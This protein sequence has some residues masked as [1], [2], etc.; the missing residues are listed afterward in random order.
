MKSFDNDL[1]KYAEKI[2][3]KMSERRELR[4]RILTYMEYHPL[5]KQPISSG[6]LAIPSEAFVM[7][8]LKALHI[9]IIA[10]A[11]VLLFV[12]IPLAAEKSKP[13]DALYFVK[14]E[15]TEPL[16][17]QFA[18]TPYEK[19]EF[20]TKLLNKRI[21]EA[22][23]LASEGKLTDE[24][25]EQI[26]ETV[27]EH[28][29]AVQTGLAELRTQ[30]ADGA[31]IAQISV[32]SSLEVQ[33]AVLGAENSVSNTSLIESILTVVNDA[34]EDVSEQAEGTQ[35]SYEGLMAQVERETTRAFELLETVKETATEEEIRDIERRLNDINRLTSESKEK[36]SEPSGAEN[37]ATTL[38]LLQKL[39][40]FMTDID[41]R[42]SVSLE[43][44]VPVVLST[45]ERI[46]IVRKKILSVNE[47][48]AR[49][50]ERLPDLETR[51]MEE[52]ISE[53][54]N[55]ANELVLK[56]TAALD[57]SDIGT[58]ETAAD[59]AYAIATDLDTLTERINREDRE[60]IRNDEADG[61]ETAT[62]TEEVSEDN[63]TSTA[64][65]PVEDLEERRDA[66]ERI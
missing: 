38:G 65:V 33:S 27:K 25:K 45:E 24:V 34:R 36:R 14:T 42:E 26:T 29:N 23:A 41:V 44:I 51:G 47:V 53:G 28:T 1:K 39:I 10:G 11:F 5:K 19:I 9:R 15:L 17:G 6:D 59:E 22:R 18:K 16:Q 7:V 2:S 37:L 46:E 30:D 31:A 43:S 12:L 61:E 58:A 20:E 35:P 49:I 64:P 52:K 8:R 55:Q 60:G 57:I 13:G 54:L 66:E 3:L 63:G 62:T 32:N 40:V 50:G 21:A 56:T 48:T 4:E